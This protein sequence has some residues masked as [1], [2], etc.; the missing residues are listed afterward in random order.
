MTTDDLAAT[1]TAH[2]DAGGVT[3]LAAWEWARTLAADFGPVAALLGQPCRID[4]RPD[5]VGLL[6]HCGWDP[7]AGCYVLTCQSTAPASLYV[8]LHELAHAL[9]QHVNQ[10]ATRAAA[11]RDEAGR[12]DVARVL[13]AAGP[14][15][16][17]TMAEAQADAVA[18]AL[19]D[20]LGFR[21]PA[22]VKRWAGLY[23]A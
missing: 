8:W 19:L 18:L 4:H 16:Y 1:I 5:M 12:L 15:D 11:K 7:D 20:V 2:R 3:G 23:D 22:A 13:A 14:P 10:H 9:C 17:I 21:Q 6:G